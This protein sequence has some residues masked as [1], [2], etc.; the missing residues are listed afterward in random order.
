MLL[1]IY[2]HV[3]THTYTQIYNLKIYIRLETYEIVK[4]VVSSDEKDGDYELEM[5]E[6][7]SFVLFF[8][9]TSVIF[10]KKLTVYNF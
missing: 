9:H 6:R 10:S 5:E 3:C 8:P 7:F 2:T 4:T 1:Y